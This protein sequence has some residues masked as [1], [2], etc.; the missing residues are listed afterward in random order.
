ML[1]TLEEAGLPWKEREI[2]D[3]KDEKKCW[4]RGLID[5]FEKK[6]KDQIFTIKY[7]EKSMILTYPSKKFDLVIGKCGTK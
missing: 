7:G 2:I 4:T 6:G 3:V 5:S 1:T